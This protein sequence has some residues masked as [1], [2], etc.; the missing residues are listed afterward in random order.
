MTPKM[1]D[2][3]KTLFRSSGKGSVVSR[4][5]GKTRM[6]RSVPILIGAE[7]S[8]VFWIDMHLKFLISALYAA[9]TGLQWKAARKLMV[10]PPITTTDKIA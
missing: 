2:K 3:I 4:G 6:A 5:I 9:W 7:A 10:T 1:K 8:R